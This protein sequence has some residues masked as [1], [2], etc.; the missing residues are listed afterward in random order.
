MKSNTY[1]REV[2][3]HHNSNTKDPYV[4]SVESSEMRAPRGIITTKVL[5]SASQGERID[6]EI[7]EFLYNQNNSIMPARGS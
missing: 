3:Q 7:L 4:Q 1:L 2:I 6:I 5:S